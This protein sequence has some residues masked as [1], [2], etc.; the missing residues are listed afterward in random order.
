MKRAHL[1]ISGEV[2]GVCY[3]SETVRHARRLNVSGW[4]R[5]L[6]DGR[7]ETVIEGPVDDVD[8]MI[9]WCSK[10][11]VLASV[12]SMEIR[13]ETYTGEYEGFSILY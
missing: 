4:V 8:A 3:R 5:N 1:F 7:V 9:A 13:E 2:Q 10:G 6:R 11:P 12:T